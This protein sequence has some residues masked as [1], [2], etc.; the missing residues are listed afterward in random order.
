MS[1]CQIYVI[2]YVYIIIYTIKEKLIT[3][4]VTSFVG[5]LGLLLLFIR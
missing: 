5:G 3:S 1:F 4:Y 2:G